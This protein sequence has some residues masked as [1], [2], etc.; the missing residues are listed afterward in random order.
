MNTLK[1]LSPSFWGAFV[2]GIVCII[3]AGHFGGPWYIV[4][5]AG[6][7]AVGFLTATLVFKKFDVGA[8]KLRVSSA[9]LAIYLIVL[10]CGTIAGNVILTV[11]YFV[12]IQELMGDIIVVFSF[13]GAVLLGIVIVV[14][15]FNRTM[16]GNDSVLKG[17]V[18]VTARCVGYSIFGLPAL[19]VGILLMIPRGLVWAFKQISS[20]AYLQAL[21]SAILTGSISWFVFKSLITN[22]TFLWLLAFVTG[23]ASGGCVL[24]LDKLSDKFLR[25]GDAAYRKVASL[26]PFEFNEAGWNQIIAKL[27]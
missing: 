1:K 24:L 9:F 27:P 7:S 13:I 19:C 4:G 22:E 14:A 17:T 15:A 12:R 5:A 26:Y 16:S 23:C 6:G 2:G 10:G 18:L 25:F 8:L 20:T 3:I 21:G 11:A